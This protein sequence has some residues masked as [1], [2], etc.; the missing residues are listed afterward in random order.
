[1]PRVSNTVMYFHD[2]ACREYEVYLPKMIKGEIVK[3]YYTNEIDFDFL[4]KAP[5]IKP[6]ISM[7]EALNDLMVV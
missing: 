3:K 1:M 4:Q 7:Q 2:S 6:R 5:F